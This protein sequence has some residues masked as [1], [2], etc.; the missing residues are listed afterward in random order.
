MQTNKAVN[1]GGGATLGQAKVQ[2][3]NV[4]FSPTRETASGGMLC[5]GYTVYTVYNG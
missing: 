3:P 2:V 4:F 1:M 5:I